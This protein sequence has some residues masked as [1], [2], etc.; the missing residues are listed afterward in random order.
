[1]NSKVIIGIIIVIAAIGIVVYGS[2][3][4]L[5]EEI[6][7]IS[8]STDD[9]STGRVVTRNLNENVGLASGP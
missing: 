8:T 3:E 2:S 4:N 7:E 1:M 5:D 6:N 9:S